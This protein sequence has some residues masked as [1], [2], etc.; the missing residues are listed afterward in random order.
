MAGGVL[1][2]AWAGVAL[3]FA[4]HRAWVAATPL[5]LVWAAAPVVALWIS[6]LPR[7]RTSNQLSPDEADAFR[8]IARRTWHF[9]ET[10]VTLKDQSLPPDNFQETPKPVIAHRT[11]PTNIGL[12]LLSTACA[13]DFGWIGT[14]ESVERL[15]ATLATIGQMELFRGHLYNWYDTQDLHPLEPKYVSTVDSGNLAGHLLTLANSCREWMEKSFVGPH[16][17]S[18]LRDTGQLLRERLAKVADTPR[19]HMVT[20][21]QLSTS[22]DAMMASIDPLPVDSADWAMRF[23][24]W[25]AQ[26]QTVA[27]IAQ[28]LQQER[29]D[30]LESE[31]H[32]WAEAFKACVESHEPRCGNP[33]SVGATGLERHPAIGQGFPGPGAG[34]G[35][36][37]TV[38]AVHA[39][40]AGCARNIRFCSR[41]LSVLRAR[42]VDGLV[43]GLPAERDTI[44]RIDALAEALRHSAA[45]AAALIRRLSAIAQTADANVSVHGIRLSV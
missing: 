33:D 17:L 31:L 30:S 32:I 1:V 14:L 10:F 23:K 12:Y 36:H 7:P 34:M 3:A 42:L 40:V 41:R 18:G 2:A 6:R 37:R 5:L 28:A 21:K 27:D 38:P 43:N 35:G 39:Q 26:A 15:E 11:S 19:T 13:R 9:F 16:L 44:E 24:E 8:L 4:G 29:G 45:D 22:V 20:L 25:S